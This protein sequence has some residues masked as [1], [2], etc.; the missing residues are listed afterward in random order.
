MQQLYLNCNL[1]SPNEFDHEK[2]EKKNII[3][4]YLG[5]Y[6]NIFKSC[7]WLSQAVNISG[8]LFQIRIFLRFLCTYR[9]IKT[10]VI[11]KCLLFYN[12]KSILPIKSQ[13]SQLTLYLLQWAKARCF[14]T[15][16]YIQIYSKGIIFK[17]QPFLQCKLSKFFLASIYY[18]TKNPQNTSILGMKLIQGKFI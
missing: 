17:S 12:K 4:Q 6:I 7:S 9:N 10:Q 3:I 18:N 14:R 16:I 15:L 5:S 13:K 11:S 2:F 8:S 1:T